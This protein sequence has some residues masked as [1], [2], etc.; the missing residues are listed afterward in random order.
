MGC[1]RNRAIQLTIFAAALI[2]GFVPDRFNGLSILAIALAGTAF[3]FQP[4]V[5]LRLR[6]PKLRL[7]K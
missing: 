3:L 1:M 5:M 7:V 4:G 6:R 2:L